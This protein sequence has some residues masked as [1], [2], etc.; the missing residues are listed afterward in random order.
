MAMLIIHYARPVRLSSENLSSTV[1]SPLH[2]FLYANSPFIIIIKR[3]SLSI[4][5]SL[6]KVNTFNYSL[7]S[8]ISTVPGLGSGF[9]R[10]LFSSFL[11]ISLRFFLTVSIDRFL[12][13]TLR[14]ALLPLMFVIE[15]Q[16]DNYYVSIDLQNFHS[17]RWL[18]APN[19]I[20]NTIHKTKKRKIQ[21]QSCDFVRLTPV[22]CVGVI[23]IGI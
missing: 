1:S 19:T 10:I 23:G 5:C 16:H 17:N 9:T 20:Q 4:T 3:F 7:T 2:Q 13:E 21:N 14:P 6:F 18:N 8:Q 12:F 22:V 11:F 15:N